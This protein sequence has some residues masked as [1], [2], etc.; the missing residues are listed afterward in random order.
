MPFIDLNKPQ[1]REIKGPDFPVG[2]AAAPFSQPVT[3]SAP[4]NQVS[5]TTQTQAPPVQTSPSPSA[6]E[7]Q[8]QPQPQPELGSDPEPTIQ[9]AVEDILIPDGPSIPDTPE[10]SEVSEPTDMEDVVDVAETPSLA[11]RASM[12][13]LQPSPVLGAGVTPAQASLTVPS[14][15]P[16]QTSPS[17]PQGLQQKTYGL[18][19]LLSQAVA[20][21]ASDLH[22]T[23]GY[24]ALARVDG[25]LTQIQ[26]Q[27]LDHESI[28]GMLEEVVKDYP[29]V[30][31]G[32][33]RDLDISYELMQPHARFRVNISR[34]QN[35][36]TAVFRVIAEKIRTPEEL[37][38]PQIVNEFTKLSQGLVLV[39]GPT[40]SGKTT[41]LAGMVNKINMAE[42]K[43]II[44]IEDPIEY[45]YP[46]G[47]ALVDQRAVYVDTEDWHNALRA[48]LRQDPD[49]VLI[50]EMRDTETMEA[51]LQVAETGHLV[52]ST[53]H[54]NSAAQT[55]DRVI[56]AFPENKQSQVRTQLATTLVA[57]VSQR[58][59]PVTGGGRRVAAEIMVVTPAIRNAIR[60]G[61]VY[62]VDNMI[63][64]GGEMGMMTMEKSLVALVREG[65]IST[66]VAQTYA[67]RPEDLLSL[68]G[69]NA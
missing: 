52:F 20:R 66:E 45:V 57:V 18:T 43:H 53:L 17:V 29:H 69:K 28:K 38:L 19:E 12:D 6:P 56:D 39:T 64:T 37:R 44:T 51:A 3:A 54:T 63:Q 9:E 1:I 65:L 24:R 36:L 59:L 27:V 34:Q 25:K 48:A 10:V 8:S 42:P 41:T 15:P 21:G 7:P 55:V 22:L 47:Q 49:V 60:E 30:D 31:L 46:K 2:G 62:Q 32:Q 58:L 68:L 50:G 11:I 16:A 33:D 35:T 4:A 14:P 67:N 13:D 26:S 61:K 40:G 5:P 23:A